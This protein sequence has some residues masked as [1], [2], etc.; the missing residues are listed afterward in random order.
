MT[1]N[2]GRRWLA[3]VVT[4]LVL[5][6][7][8]ACTTEQDTPS[9]KPTATHGP[10]F[11]MKRALRIGVKTDQPGIG[12]ADPTMTIFSGLD[13]DIARIIAD[14]LHD[15]PVFQPV[16]SGN[17][18]QMLQTRA[19]DLVIASYSI[20]EERLK[21]VDFAGPYFIAGQDTLIRAGDKTITDVDD[22]KDKVTCGAKG[23]NSPTRLAVR[24][25]GS[26]N[27]DNAWG[28]KHLKL[29]PGYS[30]CLRLLVVDKSVDAVSTDDSLL[31]GFANQPQYKGRVRLLGKRFT[32]HREKYGIGI[33]KGD[34]ADIELINEVLTQMIRDGRW[35]QIVRKH[36]GA[37]APKF[38]KPADRP[39]P[40]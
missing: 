35:E 9:V 24:F 31:A 1:N 34:R 37:E 21:K 33:A 5:T 2:H 32:S 27:V 19:V 29:V 4:A 11:A 15:T 26:E 40:G 38:L 6:T 16:V 8:A 25:G 39:T 14:A 13:I 36:L 23:S 7:M 20:S 18:E 22:L 28:R 3:G 10:L 30:D 12:Y 17:R